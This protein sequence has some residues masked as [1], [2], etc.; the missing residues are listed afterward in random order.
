[1]PILYYVPIIHSVED[2]GS[3]G[4]AIR[5]AFTEK[6]GME[7]DELQEEIRQ[8][9]QIV[10]K[11]IDKAIPDVR[12]LVVYQDSLPVGDRQKILALFGYICQDNPESQ[13]FRL[14]KKLIDG[15]AVLEGTEDI[16]LV[17]EQLKIYQRALE[18]P[19]LTEQ[20]KILDE[21]RARSDEIT[22]LRDKF[23]AK[24]VRDTLPEFGKGILFI[25]RSRDVISE[26][27][28][29]TDKFTIVCL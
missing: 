25:G 22:K 20:A 2:Y 24:R 13:N 10:D 11:R 5:A 29:L 17:M 18:A 26:L 6:W 14:V 7:I 21:N 28:K 16:N 3:L 8:Y 15:G 23:I 1:M 27:E 12:G 4:P 9:W 19:S